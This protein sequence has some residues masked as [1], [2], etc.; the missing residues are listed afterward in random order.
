MYGRMTPHTVDQPEGKITED[1]NFLELGKHMLNIHLSYW[2]L[3]YMIPKVISQTSISSSKYINETTNSMAHLFGYN[4]EIRISYI[5]VIS[6]FS[7]EICWF[8]CWHENGCIQYLY[9]CT[10][11]HISR[12]NIIILFWKYLFEIRSEAWLNWNC[13]QCTKL[14]DFHGCRFV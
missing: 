1:F 2:A 4:L 8:L 5:H 14:C 13:L 6:W 10:E 9:F 12:Q 11:Y 3:D 7:C